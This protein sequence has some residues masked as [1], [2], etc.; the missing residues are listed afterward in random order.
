MPKRQLMSVFPCVVS[1]STTTVSADPFVAS[2][3]ADLVLLIDDDEFI[4]DIVERI[5]SRSGKRV[6]RARN[7]SEGAQF[8][9]AYQAEISLVMLDCGLPDINGVT[10][11]RLFR[12][13]AP[14]LP[15]I[16]TS[17]FEVEAAQRLAEDGPTAFLP[18][19]FF[20]SQVEDLV[21]S[22]LGATT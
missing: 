18:K 13:K 16:L 9:A 15:V 8:F 17:G 1:D 20:A 10:L 21:A 4:A 3:P 19:P 2:N 6:L 12:Q 7:G 5:L 14:L 22:L 11:C